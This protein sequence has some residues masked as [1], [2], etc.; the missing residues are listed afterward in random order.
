VIDNIAARPGTQIDFS[1]VMVMVR[2][3]ARG[4]HRSFDHRCTTSA[5]SFV[6]MDWH[7]TI[8]P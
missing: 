1:A 4:W 6:L 7:E 5:A 2:L 3:C 8:A